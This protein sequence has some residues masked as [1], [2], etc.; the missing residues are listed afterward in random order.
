MSGLIVT[1]GMKLDCPIGTICLGL[2]GQNSI[3]Q[4]KR[5]A[6]LGMNP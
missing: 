3:A 5:S 1:I 6:A 2:K 4:G